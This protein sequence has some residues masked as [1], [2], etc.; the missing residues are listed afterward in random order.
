[1]LSVL[2]S[3]Y[4]ACWCSRDFRS[5]NIPSLASEELI[6]PCGAATMADDALVPS[7]TRPSLANSPL[8]SATEGRIASTQILS[9]EKL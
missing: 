3:Q 5:H 2:H 6:N 7:V 4:H 8:F 1:M 9:I